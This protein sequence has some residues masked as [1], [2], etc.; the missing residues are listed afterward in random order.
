[1][2]RTA[3]DCGLVLAALAG[4]DAADPSAVDKPFDYREPTKVDAA[5]RMKIGIIQGS[6]ERA[7]PE[8]RKNFEASVKVLR[9]FCDVDDAVA[10]PDLPFGPAVGTIIDAEGASAFR[11]LIESGRTRELRAA[12]DRWGGQAGSLVLAVDYL[13]AMRARGIMKKALD[14]LYA[15]YDALVAPARATVAP[16]I[17]IDFIKA[18]PGFASGP[19]V[20]QGGNLAGQPAISIPNG[21]GANNL[22]TGIQFTG[23]IWSEAKLIALAASYQRETDWHRR[24][25][26]VK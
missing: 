4:A 12:N 7:Q 5:T 17:Q 15:R 26:A 8:V 23:R 10:Y 22:P 2:C 11:D 1:M 16:P 14:D 19:P 6:F 24:R 25:P 13:Q 18:Y 21:F 20:I 9:Q 3:D